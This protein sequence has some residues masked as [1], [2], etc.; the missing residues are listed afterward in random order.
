ME[1]KGGKQS[2]AIIDYGKLI[3]LLKL[4]LKIK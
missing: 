2:T 4:S 1:K 3:F